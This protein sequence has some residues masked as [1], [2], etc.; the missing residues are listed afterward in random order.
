MLFLLL[1]VE[2]PAQAC[3]GEPLPPSLPA[4]FTLSLPNL[5]PSSYFS[6]LFP[7]C[8]HPSLLLELPLSLTIENSGVGGS[9]SWEMGVWENLV[10]QPFCSGLSGS[11]S[12][13]FFF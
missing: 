4:H 10:G 6:L 5:D 1:P 2:V 7:Y 13:F 11:W 3:G 12:T 8:P 9:G